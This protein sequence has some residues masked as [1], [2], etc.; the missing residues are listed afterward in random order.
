MEFSDQQKQYIR[1]RLILAEL[2][3]E[4]DEYGDVNK[5]K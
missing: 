5:T 1:D 2:Q 4:K 3:Q